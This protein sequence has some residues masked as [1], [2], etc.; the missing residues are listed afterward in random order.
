MNRNTLTKKNIRR[1]K[2]QTRKGRTQNRVDYVISAHGEAYPSQSWKL[3]VGFR[4]VFYTDYGKSYSC[5]KVRPNQI[6]WNPVKEMRTAKKIVAWKRHIPF[7]VFLLSDTHKADTRSKKAQ[8]IYGF[9]AGVKECYS[10]KIIVNLDAFSEGMWFSSMI[11]EI[12]TYHTAV[13]GI[14][15]PAYIHCLFCLNEPTKERI[16]PYSVLSAN[17]AVPD[18][19]DDGLH[20]IYERT[21]NAAN[22]ESNERNESN[23][24]NAEIWKQIHEENREET[25][26]YTM[27]EEN[28]PEYRPFIFTEN[29]L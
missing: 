13:F 1:Q 20:G 9:R 5:T 7:D 2:A 15:I 17:M 19:S 29:A 23:E 24:H 3:P 18:I 21:N 22:N 27:G 10:N 14:A 26:R 8:N 12:A 6:C 25:E 4:S 11:A 28:K 16:P